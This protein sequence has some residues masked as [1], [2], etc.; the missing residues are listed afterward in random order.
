MALE[1][2]GVGIASRHHRRLLGDAQ[3]RLAQLKAVLAGQAVEP[4]D[5]RMDE[6]GVGRKGD[7]LG[8]HGGVHSH[9]LEI[10]H[11]QRTDL[12]RDP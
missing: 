6:L 10:A 11:P 9:T 5:R 1:L 2:F 7:G 12:V 4:L 8:L 3:I